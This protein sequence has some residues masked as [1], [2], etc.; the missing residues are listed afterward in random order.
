MNLF[1]QPQLSEGVLHLD[2]EESK[3]CIRVLRK[4]SGDII[5]ITDGKGSFYTARIQNADSQKCT[6]SIA[7]K[8]PEVKKSFSIHIAISPTKNADR[9]EWFVEKVVELGIDEITLIECEH[10]ERTFIKTERLHK[11]AVSAMKQSLKATLPVINGLAKFNDLVRNAKARATFIAYVDESNPHHL[12][13]EAPPAADYLLL[14][15]PEG[16]FSTAELDLAIACGFKKVSLGT[17]RLRT[18]TAGIAA[19]HILNLVNT[20]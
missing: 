20:K 14:I 2:A 16:D 15:G 9:M 18:E 7:E 3:H 10:T 6:F 13:H 17:S 11:V 19:C 1:Y 4:K 5:T 12:K 8:T